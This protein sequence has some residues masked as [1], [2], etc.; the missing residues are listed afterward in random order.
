MKLQKH[1]IFRGR[2]FF[3]DNKQH[4]EKV[5]GLLKFCARSAS[6]DGLLHLVQTFPKDVPLTLVIDCISSWN[7]ESLNDSYSKVGFWYLTTIG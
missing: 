1:S 5:P 4:M 3:D 2:S 6:V 7:I